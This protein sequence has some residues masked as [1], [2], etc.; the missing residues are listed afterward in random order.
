MENIF[1]SIA[2]ALLFVSSLLGFGTEPNLVNPSIETDVVQSVEL[3]LSETSPRGEQGGFAM[4][5]SGCSAIPPH[6]ND[7]G[8]PGTNPIITATPSLVRYG[9]QVTISWDPNGNSSCVLTQNVTS[10]TGGLNPP[11]P[12]SVNANAPGS[13]FDIVTSQETYGIFCVGG[14]DY[15]TVKVLPRIQET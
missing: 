12:P 3:D 2:P 1:N 15:V 6:P 14:Y 11:A 8:C 7:L 13:R 4:P 5:A 9:S 10:L